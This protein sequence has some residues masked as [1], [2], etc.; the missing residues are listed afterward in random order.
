MTKPGRTLLGFF[1]GTVLGLCVYAFAPDAP[2]VAPAIT[3]VMQPVGQ[4]FL[5]IIFSA[6]VPLVFTSVVLGIY[7]MGDFRS[8]GRIA[9]KAAVY[10]VFASLTSVLIGMGLVAWIK[11]GAGFDGRALEAA[12]SLPQ[13]VD[14]IQNA[15]KTP[16][17]ME[18]LVGII[19]RN[20]L[21]A[22]LHALDGEM[23]P[24]MIFALI[25]GAALL[26]AR[27]GRSGDPL[28]R[29]LETI[30]DISMKIVDFAMILAPVAIGA[31]T[32]SMCSRFGWALLAGLGKYVVVVILGLGIQQIVIFGIVL[33]LFAKRS[34]WSFHYNIKEVIATAFS[35]SSSNATLPVSLRIADQRLR[36]NKKVSSFVLTVGVTANQNG[37]ALFGGV[38]VLFL[39]QVFNIELTIAQQIT[40]MAMSV[41]AGIGTAGVPG[42]SLP[43]IVIVLQSVGI[44]GEGIGL[45]IGVDRFL[46]MCRTVVNVS[47]DLVAATIIDA[48]EPRPEVL[49]A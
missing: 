30:R 16:N 27:H 39:A 4:I 35:T 37:T 17:A 43:L 29:V 7:E 6:V 48:T 5:R 47:G 33:G 40:V 46:D 1:V 49:D 36:L 31:L 32:F 24:L 19:P 8:L 13:S 25:F 44:P 15:A 14:I 38:T 26:A 42:G 28:I 20:P 18:I 10:T 41:L 11:P 2:W 12:G 21:D 45:I 22:G 3:Y 34:I 9:S 23:L